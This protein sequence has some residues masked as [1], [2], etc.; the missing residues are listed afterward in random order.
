MTRIFSHA[1]T[2]LIC[3]IMGFAVPVSATAQDA[4]AE[5]E[6][7]LDALRSA[8]SQSE[9]DQLSAKIW[10]HWLTAPNE[11]AQAV[12]DA[13][14][15]RRQAYDFAGA[16]AELD[17]LVETYPDYAEGWNQ[18]ATMHFMTGDFDKSLADVEEVLTREPRH[19]GAL[20][21]KGMILFQQGKLPLAQIA[22]REGLKHHPYLR[23]RAI[24]E[25]SPGTEL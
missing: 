5:Y 19:F 1:R 4:S 13:A 7:L 15:D 25:A 8:Q 22:V 11:A 18:R 20:A 6:T 3:L 14:M 16:I 23:E 2:L 9:A 12:L 21:G 17:R 10:D 24:L